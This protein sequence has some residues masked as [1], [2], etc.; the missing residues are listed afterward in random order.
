MI[1]APIAAEHEDLAD[2]VALIQERGWV[3]SAVN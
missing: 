2:Y 1:P 3:V